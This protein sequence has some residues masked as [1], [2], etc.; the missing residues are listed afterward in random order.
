MSTDADTSVSLKSQSVPG[1]KADNLRKCAG[2]NNDEVNTHGGSLLPSLI[3]HFS[4]PTPLC[5]IPF[6]S[7]F[8]PKTQDVFLWQNVVSTT[9]GRMLLKA[10]LQL[11]GACNS[12][13]PLNHVDTDTGRGVVAKPKPPTS[14]QRCEISEQEPLSTEEPAYKH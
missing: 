11:A 1:H 12:Q 14:S 2:V 6:L 8:L 3:T 13:G 9:M 4:P 10:Q 5:F 7:F